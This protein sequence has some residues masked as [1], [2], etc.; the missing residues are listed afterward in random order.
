MQTYHLEIL[1]SVA[2]AKKRTRSVDKVQT[3][4]TS[5]IFCA[6]VVGVIATNLSVA[7]SFHR[8]VIVVFFYASGVIAACVR[9]AGER[10]AAW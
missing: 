5:A 1:L 8:E 9:A 4:L 2:V 3:T 6:L 10:L 7:P